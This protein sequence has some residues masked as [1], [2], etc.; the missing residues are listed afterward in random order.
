MVQ[1]RPKSDGSTKL[2]AVQLPADDTPSL[3]FVIQLQQS[4][5]NVSS[6]CKGAAALR[7]VLPP[8]LLT[9]LVQEVTT[10]LESEPT[11]TEV[12]LSASQ[13]KVTVVGDTHGQLHDVCRMFEMFG[14]PSSDRVYI[15]NGRAFRVL[16]VCVHS[17]YCKVTTCAPARPTAP[18]M[19]RSQGTPSQGHHTCVI[20]HAA[21]LC[22]L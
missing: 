17:C 12:Q 18:A 11:L 4:M 8:T 22:W 3:E 7:Q 21:G 13:Q 16:S 2:S 20:D 15:I 5:L 10:I 1:S 6:H 19:C 9:K 14:Q